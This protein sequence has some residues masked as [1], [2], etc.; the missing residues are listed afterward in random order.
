M[1]HLL[2]SLWTN[3][4]DLTIDNVENIDLTFEISH[5]LEAAI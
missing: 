3:F 5:G 4:I 1:M 2:G